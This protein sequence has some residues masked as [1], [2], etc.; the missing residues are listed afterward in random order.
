MAIDWWC[1]SPAAGRVGCGLLLRWRSSSPLPS[2]PRPAAGN[3][4]EMEGQGGKVVPALPLLCLWGWVIACLSVSQLVSR[5][6]E[7]GGG[8]AGCRHERTLCF[9]L[10]YFLSP[11]VLHWTTLLSGG[12]A[13]PGLLVRDWQL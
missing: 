11:S 12:H 9:Y 10:F 3:G 1:L 4:E 2:F 13:P 8:S 5:G 6:P 7:G